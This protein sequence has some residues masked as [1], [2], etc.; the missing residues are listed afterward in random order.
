MRDNSPIRHDFAAIYGE[1]NAIGVCSLDAYSVLDGRAPVH[2]QVLCGEGVGSHY[3]QTSDVLKE[4]FAGF[5]HRRVD[6]V[7][8]KLSANF[9]LLRVN[10]VGDFA[11]GNEVVHVHSGKAHG[12]R[13]SYYLPC[14]SGYLENGLSE[15]KISSCLYGGGTD[16]RTPFGVLTP[17]YGVAVVELD[18]FLELTGLPEGN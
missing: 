9:H 18:L 3:V 12:E 15:D 4:K 14:I 13:V 17:D 11:F 16:V 7:A 1:C 8:N 5:H 10:Q 6:G 2:K